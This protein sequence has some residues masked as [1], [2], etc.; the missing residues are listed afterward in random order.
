[1][2]KPI[3]LRVAHE[4]LLQCPV[5][6]LEGQFL[7][8]QIYDL[9]GEDSNEFF[10]L[11]WTEVVEGEEVLVLLTFNEKDNKHPTI[12]GSV[13]T[14]ISSEDKVKE[15]LTLYTRLFNDGK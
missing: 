2:A 6:E 11:S 1:M 4:L 13:L 3:S 8:P 5:V 10:C 7:E 15:E 9:V 14:L 12:N